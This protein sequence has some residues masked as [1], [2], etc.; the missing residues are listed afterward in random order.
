MLSCCKVGFSKLCR[1]FVFNLLVLLV[2]SG[3]VLTSTQLRYQTDPF[4]AK[5]IKVTTGQ[6]LIELGYNSTMLMW[7]NL[8]I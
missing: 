7:S 8:T 2:D 1:T 6:I 5:D 3:C 4:E